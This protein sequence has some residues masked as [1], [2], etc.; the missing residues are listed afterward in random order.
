MVF[1][2][3]C[4]L[5]KQVISPKPLGLP[6]GSEYHCVDKIIEDL[7]SPRVFVVVF[8]FQTALQFELYCE[9]PV[10]AEYLVSSLCFLSRLY[11]IQTVLC[12]GQP[13]PFCC[14]EFFGPFNAGPFNAA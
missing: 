1:C 10:N 5:R 12:L 8:P 11:S 13:S 6:T 14:V 7:K 2:G 4:L 9:G 3:I